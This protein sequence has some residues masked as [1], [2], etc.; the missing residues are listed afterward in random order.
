MVAFPSYASLLLQGFNEVRE[1]ALL[2]TE[3]ESG[4]P[5]QAKIKS[6]VMTTRNAQIYLK[7]RAD[8]LAFL[9]W[10]SSSINE[11]AD[12]FNWRDPVTGATVQARFAGGGFDAAP[13]AGMCDAWVVK[14]KLETWG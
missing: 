3:M 5:K 4:P 13:M 8:Y 14:A 10:Y 7:T 1:S 9:G 6:R 11:G 2:R 12:W